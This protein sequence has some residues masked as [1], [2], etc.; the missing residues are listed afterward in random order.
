MALIPILRNS[1]LDGLVIDGR[2]LPTDLTPEE[3]L[4]CKRYTNEIADFTKDGICIGFEW[5]SFED[6]RKRLRRELAE[7]HLP[8]LPGEERMLVDL[9]NYFLEGLVL[10]NRP[11]PPGLTAKEKLFCKKVAK[12]RDQEWVATGVMRVFDRN[13][14]EF[15][16]EELLKEIEQC[17]P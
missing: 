11:L 17:K 15:Y 9:R 6:K 13:A 8:T 4:L 3:S 14:Y 5:S 1:Y 12:E 10:E 7:V 16:R 2:A